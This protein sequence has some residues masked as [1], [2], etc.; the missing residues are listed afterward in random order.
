MK[1][2][3]KDVR[4]ENGL[5]VLTSRMPYVDSATVGLWIG[6]GS[7]HEELRMA[8]VSH[9]IEHML[10]K[11]TR[12][13]T[14]REISAAIEG[15]GGYLNAFTQEENTCYYARVPAEQWERALN[16]LV[17]MFR[18]SLFDRGEMAKE[19]DVVTE[20]ILMYR[21]QPQ[22]LVEEMLAAALWKGHP[23]G[24]SVSG[25]PE[26]VAS[27]TRR[28]V[29]DF[30]ARS[31]VARNTFLVF[32]GQVDPDACVRQVRKLTAGLAAGPALRYRRATPVAPQTRYVSAVREIEQTHVALGFRIFGQSDPRRY[33]LRVLNTLVGEN[34]S[35]RLFQ[36]VREKFGLAYSIQ[37]A[38]H[39]FRD[40][41]AFV[42]TAGVEPENTVRALDLMCRELARLKDRPV[43][44]GELRRAKDYVIGQLRLGLEGT[45]HQMIWLG[46]AAL[47]P[48][49]ILQPEEVISKIQE[50]DAQSVQSLAALAFQ[51]ARASLALVTPKPVNPTGS[52]PARALQRL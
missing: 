36:V 17:D 1:L 48:G 40:S 18:N 20:E 11:G 9:F 35:S 34:M 15:Y 3:F 30:M 44:A 50:V 26:A 43:G 29:L 47:T 28:D 8:G 4:L 27:L 52:D 21:D 25:E 39:L 2:D 16:V 46:E 32:A 10:F 7:R 41:G 33:A 6:V 24:R 51:E 22:Q 45:S 14:A 38:C 5:R 49:R 13:R 42:V 12:N 37:S 23:L 19:K 31:Y